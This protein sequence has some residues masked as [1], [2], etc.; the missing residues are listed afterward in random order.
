MQSSI[1]KS[2][3]IRLLRLTWPDRKDNRTF[4]RRSKV[5]DALYFTFSFADRIIFKDLKTIC[6]H[7]FFFYLSVLFLKFDFLSRRNLTMILVF[8]DQLADIRCDLR[9]VK[10]DKK[11]LLYLLFIGILQF[12]FQ[13]CNPIVRGDRTIMRSC[14]LVVTVRSY[15]RLLH[16]CITRILGWN[17][18]TG[19]LDPCH[20]SS[21]ETFQPYLADCQAYEVQNLT[22]RH[23]N[24]SSIWEPMCHLS[25]T[26]PR[27]AVDTLTIKPRLE[28]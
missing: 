5:R 11:K 17:G 6:L 22:F 19:G 21:R 25:V 14:N 26:Q 2:C 24:L 18:G 15:V 23:I 9:T 7:L 16:C 12:Y 20:S 27:S 3:S 13:I 28:F 8:L 1:L 4:F 10:D